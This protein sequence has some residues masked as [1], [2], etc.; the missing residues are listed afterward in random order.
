[1]F[2]PAKDTIAIDAPLRIND[3]RIRAA[4]KIT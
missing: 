4:R 3:D 2:Q 1:M